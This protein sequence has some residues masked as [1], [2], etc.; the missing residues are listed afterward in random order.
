[1]TRLAADA[2]DA[3]HSVDRS[4][5]LRRTAFLVLVACSWIVGVGAALRQANAGPNPQPS[6]AVAS[7]DNLPAAVDIA[8]GTTAAELASLLD[9]LG[10]D[11]RATTLRLIDQPHRLDLATELDDITSLR[12]HL[13]AGRYD[14][15][16]TTDAR[17]LLQRMAAS[18]ATAL[19][20]DLL[21]AMTDRSHSLADTVRIAVGSQAVTN[22][23]SELPVAAG[24]LWNADFTGETDTAV[25]GL[26]AIKAA[27]YPIDT[28]EDELHRGPDGDLRLGIA[29]DGPVRP[30]TTDATLE[31]LAGR[32]L[33][34]VDARTGIAV[35]NLGSGSFSSVGGDRFIEMASVYKIAVMAVTVDEAQQGRLDLDLPVRSQFGGDE[36]EN[37]NEQLTVRDAL[38]LMISISDNATAQA[39]LRGIG[40]E[41]VNER[42]RS[43]G[44]PDVFV[45]SRPQVATPH[46][47]MA[48]LQLIWTGEGFTTE[49]RAL[50]RD[51]LQSTDQS[52]R[53][54]RLVSGPVAHK[55]GD[56]ATVVNDVGVI[57]IADDDV[58][59][60]A[61]AEDVEVRGSAD[62]AI[63]RLAALTL[64]YFDNY[65]PAAWAMAD[66]GQQR[67][68]F[69]PTTAAGPLSG[70][71][72]AIDPGHGG[73]DPGAS[74]EL[75][76][77]SRL[78]EASVTLLEAEF[79]RDRL[80]ADGATVL[81]TRCDD[82][83]LTPSQR[84]AIANT[85]GADVL[86][87]LHIDGSLSSDVDSSSVLHLTEES[88]ALASA[89]LGDVDRPGMWAALNEQHSLANGGVIRR[90]VGTLPFAMMP[91]VLTEPVVLTHPWEAEALARND[92]R[93]SE[94]LA[95][96]VDTHVDGIR[97][98]WTSRT[99]PS[100]P[101]PELPPRP[102]C[103][104]LCLDL[105]TG[106]VAD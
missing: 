13:L 60:V 38:D 24:V 75:A 48:L 44:V 81:L 31:L 97:R 94:R 50:M 41:T 4:H 25:L 78:R 19:D 51:L 39:L 32:T 27:V 52:S 102:G 106:S 68:E 12:G 63:A 1:M 79:I 84:A 73:I 71:R 64:A 20:D 66:G 33:G 59:I 91:A 62:D 55:T 99:T 21:A 61:L 29:A 46:G 28:D 10:L 34:T 26:D 104:G 35:L 83:T 87:S 23:R 88:A 103:V 8:A 69:E 7:E 80:T 70:A 72:I 53:L 47:L 49:S 93:G 54:A 101:I 56:L 16:P 9:N 89:I 43:W 105:P 15:T 36:L 86:V 45:G 95:V 96:I 76:N 30:S 58:I 77:G 100:E 6:F 37:F 85:W 90:S 92:I 57:S 18:F 5:A 11:D 74:A 82:R 2:S 42:L 98:W 17:S 3:N 65:L 22:V 67:C 14:I 40:P